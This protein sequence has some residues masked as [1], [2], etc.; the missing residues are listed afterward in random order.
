MKNKPSEQREG[1][2]PNFAAD[3]SQL[4]S[5]FKL[6]PQKYHL[7]TEFGLPN[8]PAEVQFEGFKPGHPDVPSIFPDYIWSRDLMRDMFGFWTG[9]IPA[10][11]LRGDPS[12]GKSSA[13]VQFHARLRA[14]LVFVSCHDRLE[15]HQLNGSL[16]PTASG[17]LKWVDGPVY[18]AARHGMTL[19]LDEFNTLDPGCT[20]SLNAILE[21]YSVTI[22]E[23]GEVLKPHPNFRVIATE[24]PVNS[25]LAV[26]GRNIQDAANN[27]R[28]MKLHVD[29]MDEASEK[30]LVINEMVRA[31]SSPD[32]AKTTAEIIVAT[33]THTRKMFRRND[34]IYEVPMGPRVC[35][36][37]G[38]LAHAFSSVTRAPVKHD[39]E[40]SP[41]LYALPR[42]Y[43]SVSHELEMSV[44]K[45][46]AELI[47][48]DINT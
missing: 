44:L 4:D 42:A 20:N 3:N 14:P 17:G 41:V 27:E 13:A 15:P 7:G 36:R 2:S 18:K 46:A 38:R 10:L 47:G 6:E 23:T 39:W 11:K 12:T 35:R 1:E 30:K 9:G 24:N 32:V 34:P 26:A 21:G 37:W 19:L 25:R 5:A 48:I 28:W 45:K 43:D 8:V 29:Y 31:G 22:P 16:Y 40:R 33:A